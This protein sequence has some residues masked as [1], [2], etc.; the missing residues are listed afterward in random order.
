MKKANVFVGGVLAGVL[1]ELSYKKRFRFSYADHYCG[2]AVSLT[3]P[4]TQKHYDY[5][6]FPPFFDGLLP[7]GIMLDS[8]LKR[9]KIDRDDHMSQLIAVGKD[10]VGNVTV[11]AAE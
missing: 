4:T 5:E 1:E 2:S 11:E 3:M 10:M 7:E 6:G 8:L 9:K